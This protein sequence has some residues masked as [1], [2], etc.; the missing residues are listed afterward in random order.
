MSRSSPPGRRRGYRMSPDHL[1]RSPAGRP[2]CSP[3]PRLSLTISTAPICATRSNCPPQALVCW[4][5]DAISGPTPSDH[6]PSP[7]GAGCQW[8]QQSKLDPLTRP[9]KKPWRRVMR[10]L[11]GTP[12]SADWLA[13][14][15]WR[16][17]TLVQEVGTT[18]LAGISVD[19]RRSHVPVTGS[20]RPSPGAPHPPLGGDTVEDVALR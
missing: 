14:S 2:G 3:A 13:N 9:W 19:F 15:A 12:L 6:I 20:H 18:G 7:G 4:P 11:P 8:R 16:S 1:I 17:L 5:D 10:A